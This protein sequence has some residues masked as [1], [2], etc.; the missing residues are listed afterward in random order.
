MGQI[1]SLISGASGIASGLGSLFGGGGGSSPSTGGS[2]GGGQPPSDAPLDVPGPVPPP[3]PSIDPVVLDQL[4]TATAQVDPNQ[5]PAA[6][7]GG[8]QSGATQMGPEGQAQPISRQPAQE[9]LTPGATGGQS[10]Q[11]SSQLDA[12][13]QLHTLLAGGGNPWQL[14]GGR[15]VTVNAR[16]QSPLPGLTQEPGWGTGGL[17]SAGA[18]LNAPT[19]PPRPQ[20]AGQNVPLAQT[21]M[22]PPRPADTAAASPVPSAAPRAEIPNLAGA[23]PSPAQ[24]RTPYAPPE[25]AG[26]GLG[27]LL[28]D[29][30][31]LATGN[32]Q[33]LQRIA[34]KAQGLDP[35][36]PSP[37]AQPVMGQW[38]PN[39][40]P[41]NNWMIPPGSTLGYRNPMH[42]PLPF[43]NPMRGG[44]SWHPQRG[45]T[46]HPG[47]GRPAFH[48]A[49]TPPSSYA[50]GS[51]ARD[52]SIPS[53]GDPQLDQI[54]ASLA[55][56]ESPNAPNHGY[57]ALGRWVT[58]KRG[59]RGQGVGKWQVMTYN[60]P[61]WTEKALGR[62]M[63]PKEFLNDPEA[64]NKTVDTILKG[65]YQKYGNWRD[66]V[67]MWHSGLDY[68]TARRVGARDIN[69]T[70]EEYVTRIAGG[71][72]PTPQATRAEVEPAWARPTQNW[73]VPPQ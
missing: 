18:P 36:A 73:Q 42:G 59:R 65:Y 67:S 41:R 50:P 63:T 38:N 3:D 24:G 22:P 46:F 33:A 34:Q 5:D 43:R 25:T 10:P 55:V 57:G 54:K 4:Q 2:A 64:Q 48:A 26:G 30:L 49:R 7:I 66:V 53:S 29:I 6:T 16:P 35:N 62:R 52:P 39:A 61:D 15:D 56:V 23:A 68:A 11:A 70:T 14:G 31:G 58:D 27:R 40:D 9:A 13:A 69:M 19:P 28:E 32:P 20:P 60:I 21:P 51:N 37:E 1:G 45:R 8:T 17:T 72:A 47:G 12:L 71:I 44:Y